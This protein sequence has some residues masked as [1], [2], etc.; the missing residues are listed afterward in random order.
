MTTT[1]KL[2][3]LIIVFIGFTVGGQAQSTGAKWQAGIQAGVLVYQGDLTPSYLGS[4]KTPSLGLGL[5][6]A[7]TLN[8]SFSLRAN[9]MVGRLRGNDSVYNDPG[10]RRQRNF[11][12]TTPV[13]ELSALVV[14]NVFGNNDNRLGLR[15]SPYL[16]AGAGFCKLNISRDFSRLNRAVFPGGSKLQ[17]GLAADSIV[18]T[19]ALIGVIPLGAGVA[20]ELSSTISVTWET[21]FRYTFTDRLDG[22]SQSANPANNDFYHSH[23][24]GLVF[25]FGGKNMLACPV[26]KY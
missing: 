13:T 2:A 6:L 24:I 21:N 9:L 23:T 15:F 17:L 16:F 22:F 25:K 18:G 11:N 8:A 10:W 19:P 5:N 3:G 20:Y 26:L 4:Y 1:G 12:F 7:R 14:W